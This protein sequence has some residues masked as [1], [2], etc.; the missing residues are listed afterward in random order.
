MNHASDSVAHETPWFMISRFIRVD[1]L[2][3]FWFKSYSLVV[4]SWKFYSSYSKSNHL[5][6]SPRLSYVVFSTVILAY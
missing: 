3:D 4:Y 1:R 2:S 6:Q 5:Y